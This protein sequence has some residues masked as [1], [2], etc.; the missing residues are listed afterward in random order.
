ME[1]Q[2]N[3]LLDLYDRASYDRRTGIWEVVFTTM[4]QLDKL[5]LPVAEASEMGVY[6]LV[7]MHAHRRLQ[8][9][10]WSSN[11]RYGVVWTALSKFSQ[12]IIDR[13]DTRLWYGC[14]T[15]EILWIE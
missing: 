15:N 11:H 14:N 2:T 3:L 5:S 13:F 8:S 6:A 9:S 7:G 4:R 10:K 1:A 12:K